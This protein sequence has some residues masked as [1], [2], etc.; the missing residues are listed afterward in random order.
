MN[1]TGAGIAFFSMQFHLYYGKQF[2]SFPNYFT[3][4]EHYKSSCF[5]FVFLTPK[6]YFLWERCIQIPQNRYIILAKL[7]SLMVLLTDN[8]IESKKFFR[9]TC[10]SERQYGNEIKRGIRFFFVSLE[11]LFQLSFI[12]I[13]V[14]SQIRSCLVTVNDLL[15][16][17]YAYNV[18]FI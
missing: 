5:I 13:K 12:T 1:L 8:P 6:I 4:T 7:N 2:I 16:D 11:R 18:S 9:I 3:K 17:L 14:F 10:R 15:C